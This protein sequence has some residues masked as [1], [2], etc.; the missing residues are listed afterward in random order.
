MQKESK[1][2]QHLNIFRTQTQQ[3]AL[4]EA[5]NGRN[6]KT[7]YAWEVFGNGNYRGSPEQKP[8]LEVATFE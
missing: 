4:N 6:N 8:P 7:K 5:Q 2:K 1:R 3:A